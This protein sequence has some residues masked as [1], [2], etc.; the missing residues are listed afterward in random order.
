MGSADSG[1]VGRLLPLGVEGAREVATAG[2]GVQSKPGSSLSYC[3]SELSMGA[4]KGRMV[5]EGR[6]KNFSSQSALVGLLLIQGDIYIFE[7][8]Q[9]PA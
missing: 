7:E 5:R 6:K 3:S 4:R 1:V 9:K 8:F 2:S